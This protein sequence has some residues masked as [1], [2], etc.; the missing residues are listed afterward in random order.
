MSNIK[1]IVEKHKIVVVIVS[2]IIF[3]GLAVSIPSL[4]KLKNRNTI[5]TVSSWDGSVATSFRKGDG[6]EENPY[7]ISNGSELAFFIEQLKDT[8]YKGVYF[9]LSNDIV[10]NSGVFDYNETEG[11]KY[12]LEDITYYVKEYTNEYYDNVN[13]EGT[14]VGTINTSATINNFKGNLNGKSFTIFGLHITDSSKENLAL[15]ENLEGTI[16]DLYITN[17]VVYGV[18]NVSGIAVNATNATLSNLVYDGFVVNKSLSKI[19]ENDIDS[20]SITG[21]IAETT[22]VITLPEVS[23]EGVVKS[24]KLTGEYEVSNADSVNTIKINGVDIVSNT[25]ELDLTANTLTEIPVVVTSTIEGTSVNFVNL[26]YQIEYYDDITAGMIANSTNN[27]LNNAINKSDIYGN[28]ISA[29]FVGKINESLEILQSYNTGNV[30]SSYIGAGIVGLIN[31]NARDTIITNVYN[32]GL[33]TAT[34]SG[35]IIGI[36]TDNTGLVNINN[37]INTSPNYS[38]NTALNTT[39][40]VVNSYSTNELSI[41]NGFLNGTFNQTTMDSLYTKEFMTNIS[42]KEFVSFEDVLI[43]PDNVW[44]YE[45]SSLPI[46]YID[47]LNNPISNIN[48]SKYSWNNLS[49]ELNMIDISTNITFSIDDV[50]AVNP[51]KEKYYYITNSRVP[52][53]EEELTNITAWSPYENAVTIA[54]SGYYVIYAKIID[55]DGE[56]TY[57][58]TD[59]MVLNV[60]GFQ[61]NITMDDK[62]WESFKLNLD[63]LYINKDINLTIYAHDDLLTINSIEY[64]I[65]NK[66]LTE[67]ELKSITTWSTYTNHI[68]LNTP[69]KYVVYAKI[70]DSES[71]VR[72]VNTDYLLYGGYKETLI[73]GTTNNN[74]N[75]NYITNKSSIKLIFESDFEITYQD[76]YT[77]NLISNILLPVGTK[78]T[79]IDKS[80]NKVYRKTIDTEEDLYGYNDSCNGLSSC[81]KYATYNFELFKEIGTTKETYYDES[82]NY[83]KQITSEKYIITIDFKE[84]NLIDNYYDLSF[85]L[86]LKSD[87]GEN[88]YQTL[89]NTI[90]N[91]NIYSKINDSEILTTHNLTSDYNN[92]TVYYNSNSEVG[93]NFKNIISYSM[94][95][96]KSII[97]T[98]YES[99][100]SGLLV[101]LYTEEGAEISKQYLDNILFEVGGKEYF[102]S[103]DNSIKI[104]LGSASDCDL[105]TLTIKTKENSSGLENGTYYIKINK[106]ISAD[107]YHYDSLYEDE[108]LITLVVENQVAVIPNHSFEV[109]LNSDSIVLDKKTENHL[110]S[111]NIIYSGNLIEPNIRVSL[112][113][114]NDLTA[115]NQNYTLVDIAEYSNNTLISSETNKYF[116]DPL[117]QTFNLNLIPSKFDNNGYKYVFE[118]YDG[119]N[120]I[121]KMEK[122]F[123]VK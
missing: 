69:G 59:I 120:K 20:I 61:T 102:S 96:N 27:S 97:D 118:L 19:S 24:I 105:K 85:Y 68:T 80:T 5:Y 93:I 109:V 13:R 11:L 115:Y 57:I 14:S 64:Y 1:K 46:L 53:T 49:T 73:L 63:E 70:I 110:A 43:N 37:V 51:V 2:L 8:D 66:E 116:V 25:F 56:V 113:K 60:S 94:I 41:F 39:V 3:V 67:E 47:D 58:N 86:L 90:G 107:G 99:K 44:V 78:I 112:Y 92:Q 123:I 48:I 79:L 119:K 89:N 36:A 34:N 76:G 35:A 95:N 31:N 62:I 65:S 100:K 26:K 16:K 55:T 87:N 12:T 28:Y 75:T 103:N 40:N 98:T 83:N 45:K 111:F 122:Y 104:N 23:V 81:S 42:Y 17:S 15:F 29:G 82:V 108:I 21:T 6:T 9:E 30:K 71:N 72:Y 74:Y 84:A 18:G 32:T 50:S 33:V 117:N 88:L 121:S 7:I 54:E 114:K 91:I 10:I 52:L 101:K 106:F 38:I 22:T 77:H 4:A